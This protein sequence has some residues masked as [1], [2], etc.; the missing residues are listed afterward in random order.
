MLRQLLNHGAL[1][2]LALCLS[3]AETRADYPY[4][5]VPFRDV[6]V[7]GGFLGPRF[8]TNRRTSVWYDFGKSEETGRIDNFAK[9][10]KLMAGPFHGIPVDDSDVFKV[11]EGASYTLAIQPDAKLDSYLDDLIAKITAAQET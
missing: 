5:P 2:I 10:G 7:A 1:A 9:A 6:R 11:I 8:E 4:V 3:P